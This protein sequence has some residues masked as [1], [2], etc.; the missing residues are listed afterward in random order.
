MRR[1]AAGFYEGII[2]KAGVSVQYTNPARLL[3]EVLKVVGKG[4][5]FL[6]CRCLTLP[7]IPSVGI[8]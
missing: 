7:A 3:N 6:T 1:V 2:L 5:P 8:F 4:V